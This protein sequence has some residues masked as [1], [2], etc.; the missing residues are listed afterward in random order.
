MKFLF[1][2]TDIRIMKSKKYYALFG[3]ILFFICIFNIL[4]DKKH[5][6]EESDEIDLEIKKYIQKIKDKDYDEEK[7]NQIFGPPL[8]FDDIDLEKDKDSNFQ[9]NNLSEQELNEKIQEFFNQGSL[10]SYIVKEGDTLF[11]IAKEFGMNLEEI[12]RLN[13]NLK[14]KPLYVGDKINVYKKAKVLNEY[15]QW[16]EKNLV[17]YEYKKYKVQKGDSLFSIAKRY[18]TNVK[19]LME[20]NNLKPQQVIHPGEIL[21]VDKIKIIKKYKTRRIFIQPVDGYIT[22]GYGYRIN[23]FIP[24]LKH[25]HKGVDFAANI[26]ETVKAARDGLVIFSGRMEGFGNCIFIRHQDGYIT[27]Y[28]HNKVNKVK[29][30]DVVYQGQEIAEVGRTGY[31]TGPHLHFEVR[32]LD[33]PINPLYAL[34]MEEK[35][36]LSEQKIALK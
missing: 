35:I 9:F 30:G 13:P 5:R 17:I 16:K 22:S 1:V 4:P 11:S 19:T 36:K 24:S 7:L 26:G 10:E 2:I 27:V 34:Q 21:I 8:R 28:G 29:V 14:G 15:N 20:F 23:P 32:K 33:Q 6:L 31:A 25:F 18:N 12:Y 3:I